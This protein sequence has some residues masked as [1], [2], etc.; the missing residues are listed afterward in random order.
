MSNCRDDE[1]E[2]G[3]GWRRWVRGMSG[4]A[5][6]AVLAV[7][8][9]AA[10]SRGA[11]IA[12]ECAEQIATVL[13][14]GG[15]VVLE[16]CAGDGQVGTTGMPFAQPLTVRLEAR[17]AQPTAAGKGSVVM[18]FV[19]IDFEVIAAANGAGATPAQATVVTD[20]DGIA[21]LVLTANA[22]PGQF[23]VHAQ[24]RGKGMSNATALFSL[25]S[26]AGGA[27]PV[28]HNVPSAS[29]PVLMVLALAV[30]WLAARQ[31]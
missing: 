25:S 19:E 20:Q 23:Q 16:I 11:E 2:A 24:A 30:W 31:R 10:A 9:L 3:A 29:L 7:P 26:V 13:P 8:A 27:V 1:A 14:K 12:G 15:E 28:V 18:P 5:L 6:V 21:S 22:I 17:Q 4:L